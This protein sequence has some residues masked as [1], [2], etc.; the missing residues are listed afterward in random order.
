VNEKQTGETDE[1]K[2]NEESPMMGWYGVMGPLAGFVMI[3]FWLALLGLIIWAVG[4][5]LPGNSGETTRATSESAVEILDRR[6][7]NGEI[8]MH[9][10]QAQRSALMATQKESA[11]ATPSTK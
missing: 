4:R 6:M 2:A 1:R 7:A 3:V 5:L 8:D 11:P 10:W 9:D